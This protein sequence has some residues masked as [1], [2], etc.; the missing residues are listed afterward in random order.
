MPA[1]L[2][3][4]CLRTW[5]AI[6]AALAI[7]FWLQ[8][9]TPDS[10]AVCVAIL[11]Q[12]TRG[13]SLS[14]AVYRM[15]GTILGATV[16]VLLVALFP[17]DRF[18]LLGC[19]AFW[20]AGCT[21]AGTLLRDFR[22][23]G[24]VLSG[25][26]VSI[27]GIGV[28]DDPGNTFD[29]AAS[30]LAVIALGVVVTTVVNIASGSP[31]SR[32]GLA[33]TLAGHRDRVF[34]IADDAVAGRPVPG[35]AETAALAASIIGLSTQSSYART[36]LA[37]G[38]R[39]AGGAN[40]AILGMLDM[41]S[42]ARAI[43]HGRDAGGGIAASACYPDAGA[44]LPVPRDP[45][46]AFLVERTLALARHR[47]W[48]QDGLAA[49]SDGSAA[50][51]QVRFRLHADRFAAGLNAARVLI[52]F[53]IG[54][55]FSILSGFSDASLALIQVSA[56]CALAAT[57]PDPTSFG[58]GV[59]AGAPLAIAAAAI[60]NFF[61]LTH[62]SAMPLLAIALIPPV[63][64]ACALVM[65]PRTGSAGFIML[66]FT[67]VMLDPAN[68]QSYDLTAFAERGTMFMASAVIVFLALVLILPV[69]PRRRVLRGATSIADD[70]ARG[71]AGP[72]SR[73]ETAAAS[74]RHDRLAQ[75][76][77]W[78]GRIGEA[79]SRRFVLSRLVGLTDLAG[80]LDRARLALSAALPM[81]ALRGPAA[82]GLAISPAGD[83]DDAIRRME[84]A[85]G[86]LLAVSDPLTP[87]QDRTRLRA[88]SG[89]HG[90]SV[91]LRRHRRMLLLT[92][93]VGEK[94]MAR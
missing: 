67:F 53:V 27:V 20:L 76:S 41:L 26:T 35:N 7:A 11:A 87:A 12:P 78:N 28:I 2:P 60:L 92:G 5:F 65:N 1:G 44:P 25:Y 14:K 62:G 49:L 45:A 66:V 17:Q 74:R 61:W 4:F 69:S 29:S 47:H 46:Q 91:L 64:I 70:I 19:I 9:D 32:G 80:A 30:R 24:A 89:L 54:A 56:I 34:A 81:A 33:A 22:A 37:D 6:V 55:G 71:L 85:A 42:C 38:R 13:Q 40:S 94:G 82:D 18:M 52:A 58:L 16:A 77:Q 3:G 90:A 10:A 73:D 50:G 57:N 39:R 36:E 8:L 88:V 23:Y 68:P 15:A 93:V 86:A 51:R 21:V 84:D 59:L 79:E 72:A 31:E 83:V 48:V 63:F 43:A 75:L